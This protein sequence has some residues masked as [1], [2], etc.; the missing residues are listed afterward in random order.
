MWPIHYFGCVSKS[1]VCC[2]L[3]KYVHFCPLLV[4]EDIDQ[5]HQMLV[6]LYISAYLITTVAINS[7]QRF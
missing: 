3:V 4:E 1:G 5:N 6:N 7:H 2:G